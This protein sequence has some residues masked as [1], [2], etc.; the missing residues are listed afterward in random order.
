MKYV[1][2]PTTGESLNKNLNKDTPIDSDEYK[3]C[4]HAYQYAI[5]MTER[6]LEQAVEG[7]YHNLNTL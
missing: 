6:E 2:E 5:D 1:E 7:L 3:Y 4:G